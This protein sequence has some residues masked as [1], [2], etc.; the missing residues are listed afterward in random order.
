MAEK[1]RYSKY[2]TSR[3]RVYMVVERDGRREH[4]LLVLLL[5]R[6]AGRLARGAGLDTLCEGRAVLVF[7]GAGG[8]FSVLNGLYRLSCRILQR[9]APPL[10]ALS[11]ARLRCWMSL[12]AS[13]KRFV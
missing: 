4:V 7:E 1:E 13:S 12:N 6:N 11:G 9:P 10:L 2:S 8:I 3:N 5:T